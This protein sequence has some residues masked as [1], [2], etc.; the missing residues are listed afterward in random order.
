MH[1]FTIFLEIF[2]EKE[3]FLWIVWH[4]NLAWTYLIH[5]QSQSRIQIFFS[6]FSQNRQYFHLQKIPNK[7]FLVIC[8][9][10]IPC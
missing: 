1:L 5:M 9:H 10:G 8:K 3:Q 4:K 7:N 6:F 2:G